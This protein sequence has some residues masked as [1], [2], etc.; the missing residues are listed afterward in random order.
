M[1]LII[2][3]RIIKNNKNIDKIQ[4]FKTFTDNNYLSL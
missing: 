3:I 1:K 2:A 4:K